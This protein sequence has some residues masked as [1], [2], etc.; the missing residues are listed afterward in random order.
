ML[1]K[2]VI[3]VYSENHMDSM[4][5]FCGQIAVSLSVKSDGICGNYYILKGEECKNITVH[6]I[7][8]LKF[9]SVT[10]KLS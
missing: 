6:Y 7:M 9:T 10:L 4:H 5:T 3:C 2:Y 1:V 8:F